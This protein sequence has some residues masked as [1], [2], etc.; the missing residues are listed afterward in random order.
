MWLEIIDGELAFG[1]QEVLDGLSVGLG[2]GTILGEK[3]W[4]VRDFGGELDVVGFNVWRRDSCGRLKTLEFRAQSENEGFGEGKKLYEGHVLGGDVGG[5]NVL[6]KRFVD[7]GQ[8]RTVSSLWDNI[9][10][11]VNTQLLSFFIHW[12]SYGLGVKRR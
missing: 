5:C 10:R 6:E 1:E 12:W 8:K 11:R 7:R 2:L 4:E 9:V 3:F